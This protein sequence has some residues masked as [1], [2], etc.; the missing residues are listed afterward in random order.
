MAADVIRD[1]DY[2][3]VDE[4]GEKKSILMIRDKG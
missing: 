2:A 1:G 4:N 3:V